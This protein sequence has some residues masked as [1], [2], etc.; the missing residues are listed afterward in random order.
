MGC[1]LNNYWGF[2]TLIAALKLTEVLT[3][4]VILCKI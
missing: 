2:K 3:S 4:F 1:L